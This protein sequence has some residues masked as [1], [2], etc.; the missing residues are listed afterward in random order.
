MIRRK[1]EENQNKG[2]KLAN[3]ETELIREECK[4]RRKNSLDEEG[5]SSEVKKKYEAD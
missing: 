3:L 5:L 1:K 4:K 2:G